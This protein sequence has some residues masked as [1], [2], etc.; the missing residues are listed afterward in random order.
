[1]KKLFLL[2]LL[3]PF[4]SFG[5]LIGTNKDGLS[6]Q[7][8]PKS[9]SLWGDTQ[10]TS[11]LSVQYDIFEVVYMHNP[12]DIFNG[13]KSL[14]NK[15]DINNDNFGIFVNPVHYEWKGLRV[16]LGAGWFLKTLPDKNGSNL[17]FQAELRWMFSKHFGVS[18]KHNSNG[19]GLL[20][21]WNPGIDNINFVFKF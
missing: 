5:Q 2:L 12:D 19:F 1:M 4:F 9:V 21:D 14:S 11:R 17:T 3:S 15:H 6:L 8:S 16:Q 18:Y 13:R 7:Y 10:N 20:N